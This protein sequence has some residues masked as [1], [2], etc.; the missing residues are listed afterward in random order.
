MKKIASHGLPAAVLALLTG[1]AVSPPSTAPQTGEGAGAPAAAPPVGMQ[2]APP[3]N[4]RAMPPAALALAEA[5]DRAARVRDWPQASRQLE[6]ALGIAPRNPLL[7]QRL[8]AVRFSQGEYRQAQAFAQKS[9]SLAGDDP[10]LRKMNW[11]IIAAARRALGDARGA[12]A[13]KRRAE[14]L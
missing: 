14:A 7:W 9:N 3:S 1:C 13:A 10:A 5:A 11:R 2:A 12:A 8:A 6:R 4:P